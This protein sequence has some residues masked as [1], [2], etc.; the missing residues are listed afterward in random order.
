MRDVRRETHLG[1]TQ[2]STSSL[3][4][5]EKLLARQSSPSNAAAAP[6][7][8]TIRA[9]IESL[10]EMDREIITL[11]HFEVLNHRETA[12]VLGISEAAAAKQRTFVPWTGYNMPWPTCPGDWRDCER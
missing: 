8:R 11:R 6:N 2:P 10:D 7:V 3:A 9:A 12:E 1:G 5:A 4:L